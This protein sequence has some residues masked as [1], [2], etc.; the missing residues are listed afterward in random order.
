MRRQPGKLIRNHFPRD[1]IRT[2][3]GEGGA[4]LYAVRMLKWLLEAC[5]TVRE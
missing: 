3:V 1:V 2:I 4:K 5:Q